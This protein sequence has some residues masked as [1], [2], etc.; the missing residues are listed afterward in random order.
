MEII[1]SITVGLLVA[2]GIWMLL[3]RSLLRVVLGVIVLGNG[4]NLAVFV[5]GR[6]DGRAAAFVTEAG[7]PAMAANP[8]PQALVLTAIVIGFALFVFALA[9]LKRTW[10]VHDNIETDRITAV[11]EEPAPDLPHCGQPR[12]SMPGTG[13][14]QPGHGA[15]RAPPAAA[16][17]GRA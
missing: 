14:G 11:A 10:E 7:A 3:D 1:A 13:P 12:P 6:L 9:V 16:E 4:V 8:L 5:A 17:G 15:E 2:I